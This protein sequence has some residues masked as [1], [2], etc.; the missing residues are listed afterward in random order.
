MSNTTKIIFWTLFGLFV[1]YMTYNT[2]CFKEDVMAKRKCKPDIGLGYTPPE[3]EI[4][5]DNSLN[6]K[7]PE[8][9]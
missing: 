3:K 8:N 2:Y 7:E 6:K 5:N 1:L 9:K 4:Q